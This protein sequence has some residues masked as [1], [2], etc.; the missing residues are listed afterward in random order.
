MLNDKSPVFVSAITPGDVIIRP[1]S[2][3]FYL[4]LEKE[5][6]G[7][8]GIRCKIQ[9]L[10]ILDKKNNLINEVVFSKDGVFCYSGK[11]IKAHKNN[12]T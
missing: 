1:E 2:D 10:A 8:L 12:D 5:D 6:V 7:N 4:I 9:Y 3:L 11:L